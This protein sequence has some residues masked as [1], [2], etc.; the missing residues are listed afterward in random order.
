MYNHQNCYTEVKNSLAT[1]AP[2]TPNENSLRRGPRVGTGKSST[3]LLSLNG[4]ES[5]KWAISN[6]T[7]GLIRH[8][9]SPLKL[10][11]RH[12]DLGTTPE[13]VGG[14]SKEVG[15]VGV[16][17]LVSRRGTLEAS[18]GDDRAGLSGLPPLESSDN[19][20]LHDELDAIEREVPHNVPDP[21]NTNPATR[22]GVDFTETPVGVGS[23]DGRDKLS[24]TESH[25]KSNGRSLSP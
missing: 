18:F 11:L 8:Q 5:T 2:S 9:N 15:S 25:H 1:N 24:E 14:S 20:L 22:D 13:S 17:R 7:N 3:R 6:Q 21:D 12:G 19:S 10:V 4:R 16:E 23:D